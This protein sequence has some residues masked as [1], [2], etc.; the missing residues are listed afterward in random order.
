VCSSDLKIIEET[1]FPIEFMINDPIAKTLT[2]KSKISADEIKNLAHS[3]VS[4]KV[5]GVKPEKD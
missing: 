2:K 3:I 5:Y 4:V 1:H